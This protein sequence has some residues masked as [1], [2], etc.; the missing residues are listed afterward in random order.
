MT[1]GRNG[2][3][4]EWQK[5]G[6]NGSDNGYHLVNDRH[7]IKQAKETCM[8][9]LVDFGEDIGVLEEVVFLLPH[10]PLHLLL[11]SK[12]NLLANLDG[13]A[14][15]AGQEH[16]LALLHRRRDDAARR[17]VGCAWPDGDDPRLGQGRGGHAL[18]QE[19]P[20]RRLLPSGQSTGRRPWGDGRSGP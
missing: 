11:P 2:R 7:P 4:E 5:G 19:E 18:R 8:G 15:P 6:R 9:S 10:Q 14:A 16:H 3:R 12:T 13:I 1:E 20:C 17:R